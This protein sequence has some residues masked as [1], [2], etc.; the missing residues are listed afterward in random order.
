M[1]RRFYFLLVRHYKSERRDNLGIQ[2]CCCRGK[3]GCNE[4]KKFISSWNSR[5]ARVWSTYY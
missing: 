3:F 4:R 5:H 2:V 1:A